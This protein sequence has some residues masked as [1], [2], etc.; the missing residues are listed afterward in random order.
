MT[1]FEYA[2]YRFAAQRM[3]PDEMETAKVLA[4][5]G[6]RGNLSAKEE[7]R[8]LALEVVARTPREDERHVNKIS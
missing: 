2:L 3:T 7:L 6:D 1:V 8:N 5:M 4:E